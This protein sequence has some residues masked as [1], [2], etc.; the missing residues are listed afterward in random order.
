VKKTDIALIVF[1]AGISIVIAYFV[2]KAVL[3]DPN[4][5]SVMVKTARPI[6]SNV[7]KP[8]TDIFNDEAINPTVEICIGG[9]TC[10]DNATE[11]STQDS[12]DSSQGSG[13]SSSN[14]GD[15]TSGGGASKQP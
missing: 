15:E 9:G 7:A 10:T 11:N 6:S 5:Q 4:N 12:S 1:I 2:A 3:G 8:S 13:S 14:T